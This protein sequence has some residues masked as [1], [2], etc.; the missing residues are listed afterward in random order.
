MEKLPQ[1]TAVVRQPEHRE[2]ALNAAG[3]AHVR[4]RLRQ[5]RN[6][7]RICSTSPGSVV[8][9]QRGITPQQIAARFQVPDIQHLTRQQCSDQIDEWRAA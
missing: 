5:A 8:S 9:R 7:F 3:L 1:T 4:M 6:N 2:T